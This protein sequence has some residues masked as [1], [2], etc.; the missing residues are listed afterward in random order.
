MIEMIANIFGAIIRVIYN[1][2]QDNYAL[3]IILFTILTKALL[4]P[5][6]L[7]Q[8]K[9]SKEL[10]KI[11]PKYDEIMKKYKNDK[12]K[13]GEE[14]AKL[15]SEHKINPLGGCLP[16]LI[17]IPLILGM[18]YIVRQPLTYVV[19]MPKDEIKIYTEQVLNKQEVTD[20]EM[21]SSEITIA[22]NNKIIDMNF[23]GLNLGEKPADV[24]SSNP[25]KRA[26]P[27][28]L[29]IPILSVLFSIYQIK[30]MQKTNQ[31][32]EEQIE[33]QKS[34]NLMMP[35]LSGLIAYTMP[36]ALGVYWLVGSICQIAQQSFIAKLIEE[37]NDEKVSLLLNADKGGKSNEKNN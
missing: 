8:I 12:T 11:K 34:M 27:F 32:T 29:V 30:Q 31:M 36:L 1:L 18:Y 16:A 37:Q 21:S 19:Q 25:A 9:S 22:N 2:T 13:Q 23:I 20:M 24:F 35:M 7:K 14:I 33:M 4:F 15:Y 3:S 28:S 5:L 17:Q 10:Q 6:S 26:N